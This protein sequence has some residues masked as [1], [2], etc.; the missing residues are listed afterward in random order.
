MSHTKRV[1]RSAIASCFS[2]GMLF[3]LFP[4]TSFAEGETGTANAGT[5]PT[6]V[7][8]DSLL[9]I[10]SVAP[11]GYN[12]SDDR[13]NPYGIAKDVPTTVV[14]KNELYLNNSN[15]Q[16]SNAS[17]STA[18]EEAHI[19]N[20]FSSGAIT[21]DTSS[22]GG[23]VSH[24]MSANQAAA[25]FKSNDPH[26]WTGYKYAQGIACDL[27]RT[28]Q[29]NYVAYVGYDPSDT[30]IVAW[31]QNTLTDYRSPSIVVDSNIATNFMSSLQQYEAMNYLSITAGDYDGDGTDSIVVGWVGM[32]TDRKHMEAKSV[33]F[34]YNTEFNYLICKNNQMVYATFESSSWVSID[35][36][37]QYPCIDLQTGDFN[38]DGVEDL[39]GLGYYNKASFSSP[40]LSVIYGSR[41]HPDSLNTSDEDN[42][43]RIAVEQKI[44]LKGDD[45]NTVSESPADASIS[46]G[47]FNGDGKTEIIVA[48]YDHQYLSGSTENNFDKNNFAAAMYSIVDGKLSCSMFTTAA[49]NKFTYSGIYNSDQ[50]SAQ[51]QTQSV[52]M[53]SMT[54]GDAI[55][56]GGS[57]YKTTKDSD[58]KYSLGLPLFTPD[59]F[60]HSDN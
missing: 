54:D 10:D 3:T 41:E 35:L 20:Q 33:E 38:G 5:D 17:S 60:T 9:N 34:S 57:I 39:A 1:V 8:S 58:T 11:A 21:K 7:S 40:Y 49:T 28:G 30:A 43:R 29:K 14:E 42:I 25:G 26:G 46:A 23:T 19:F 2:L 44:A 13:T 36:K 12:D 22:S 18:G 4:Y 27:G 53:N 50:I 6:T 15:Y 51:L 56:I 55:F 16:F 52:K 45:T 48:G 47:D 24:G 59:Y 31:V 32:N 37:Y